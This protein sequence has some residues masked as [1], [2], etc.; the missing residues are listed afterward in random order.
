VVGAGVVDMVLR[1]GRHVRMDLDCML[2]RL[3]D[4]WELQEGIGRFVV[5]R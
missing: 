4:V 5:V 2:V 3:T 1:S